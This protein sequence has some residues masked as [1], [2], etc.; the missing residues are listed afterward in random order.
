[1]EFIRSVDLNSMTRS[2]RPPGN[3]LTRYRMTRVYK[4]HCK[5]AFQAKKVLENIS[6]KHHCD[7]TFSNKRVKINVQHATYL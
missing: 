5:R 7:N 3:E 1:M 6:T 4:D 2:H